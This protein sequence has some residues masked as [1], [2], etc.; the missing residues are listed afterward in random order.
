MLMISQSVVDILSAVNVTEGVKK[1]SQQINKSYVCMKAIIYML[2]QDIY[3]DFTHLI[4]LIF[5]KSMF[6]SCIFP[7]AFV[8]FKECLRKFHIR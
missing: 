8:I 3:N 1:N 5:F 4:S 6:T 7:A 2:I